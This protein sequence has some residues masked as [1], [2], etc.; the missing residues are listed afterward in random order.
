MGL[1]IV[2]DIQVFPQVSPY[3]KCIAHISFDKGDEKHKR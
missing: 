2:L 1:D 3:S